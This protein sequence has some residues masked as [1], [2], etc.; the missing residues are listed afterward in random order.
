MKKILAIAVATA[1]SAPA[2]ADM[3]I[4]GTVAAGYTNTSKDTAAVA[5]S[6]DTG[7]TTYAAADTDQGGFGID[8]AAITIS[9]SETLEN[10]LT[11]AGSMS[12]GGFTRGGSVGGENASLSISSADMGTFKIATA[13]GGSG[14]SGVTADAEDLSG[15]VNNWGAADTDYETVSYTLP[16]MGPATLGLVAY[17]T[18]GL[19]DGD[20]GRTFMGTLGLDFGALTAYANYRDYDNAAGDK[21]VRVGGAYDAGSFVIKAGY[22][23]NDKSGKETALGVTVPM[24]ALSLSAAY[25]TSEDTTGAND[26]DGYSVGATYALSSNV[27]VNAK[28]ASWDDAASGES[29]DKTAVLMSISF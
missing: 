29:E 7:Y 8:T 20:E 21:R 19:G 10:G 23:D 13:N 26:V 28:T 2:M 25:S 9:G 5:G 27:S 6:A 18:V 3:T 15:E 1:I 12:A 17:E 4:S 22:E 16:A 11:V 24:G 14:I